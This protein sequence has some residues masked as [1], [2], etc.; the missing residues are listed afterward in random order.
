MCGQERAPPSCGRALVYPQPFLLLT[1]R[2]TVDLRKPPQKGYAGTAIFSLVEP[3]S[4]SYDLGIKKH[5]QEGRTITAEF[6]KFYLVACYV[7]NAGQNLN[8]LDYRVKEW[9]PDFQ[10]Y[11]NKLK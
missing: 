8:R 3:I 10:Q 4:V 7:P 2:T 1:E 9:D 11:L 5:D 6:D